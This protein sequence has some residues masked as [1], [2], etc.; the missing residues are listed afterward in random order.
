MAV[1]SKITGVTI[2]SVSL[3]A[4]SIQF[5]GAGNAA[6]ADNIDVTT[7]T[8]TA[9]VTMTRPLVATGAAGAKYSVTVEYFGNTVATSASCSCTLPLIGVSSNC[10]VSASSVTFGT[11]DAIRGSVTVLVP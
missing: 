1:L 7:L 11:N 3:D 4:Y 5:S 10:T 9:V 2:N 6:T 8:D